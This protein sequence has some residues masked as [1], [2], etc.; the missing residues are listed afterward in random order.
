VPD[1]TTT[2]VPPTSTAIPSPSATLPASLTYLEMA[3]PAPL[4]ALPQE[5]AEVVETA[6]AGSRLR[7]VGRSP[8][9]MWVAVPALEDDQAIMWVRR[10]A[11][12]IIG[13]MD[14]IPVVPDPAAAEYF[15]DRG[16]ARSRI[17]FEPGA[18]SATYSGEVRWPIN[19]SFV[20][21]AMGDQHAGIVI[22]AEGGP[23]GFQLWG[24][25][26]GQ[27]YKR[28][29]AERPTWQGTLPRSQDYFLDVG[30]PTG[31]AAY[32][33]TLT[34]LPVS[35]SFAPPTALVEG[36]TG[37]LVGAHWYDRWYGPEIA[38]SLLPFESE[39]DLIRDGAIQQTMTMIKAY[40]TGGAGPAPRLA[41]AEPGTP[42][43][44]LLLANVD[45]PLPRTAQRLSP[46]DEAWTTV[47]AE[48]LA[49]AGPA[50][51]QIRVRQ[52]W[53]VDL[54]GDGSDEVLLAAHYFANDQA[55]P[56]VFAGDYALLLLLR[57]PAGER[58]VTAVVSD[59]YPEDASL[60][61][62]YAYG[63]SGVLDLNGDGVLEIV[64]TL[65]R[66]EG[67]RI[68]VYGVAPESGL[69]EPV[70]EAGCDL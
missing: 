52:V 35:Q 20:F 43:D 66:Y 11:G 64:V 33:I 14:V 46:E 23:A 50:D 34:I 70:L 57:G 6:A 7:I 22:E 48:H 15:P 2:P 3:A 63:L 21:R 41:P 27:P 30:V 19:H 61:Y 1:P 40:G 5:G 28:F 49:G 60:V 56:A 44:G 32:T 37:L 69:P 10:S 39:F 62:P 55:L 58:S 29:V 54:E 4:R 36:G 31:S 13:R 45:D 67:H 65:D 42:F 12:E 17:R 47:V 53:Q 25:E 68:R 38:E 24:A 18:I 26:D 51:A 9:E 16:V 8:D 59:V